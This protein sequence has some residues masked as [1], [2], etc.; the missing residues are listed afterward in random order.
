[1]TKSGEVVNSKFVTND[2]QINNHLLNFD[3]QRTPT[4]VDTT[5][6]THSQYQ[7]NI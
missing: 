4:N 5:I 6:G 3:P 2:E 7:Y 1:M